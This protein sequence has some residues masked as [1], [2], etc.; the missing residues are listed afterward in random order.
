MVSLEEDSRRGDVAVGEDFRRWLS[1]EGLQ[2]V[3]VQDRMA[4]WVRR[5]GVRGLNALM[6]LQ[7]FFTQQPNLQYSPIKTF[8]G[9][10]STDTLNGSFHLKQ[11]K[12]L[13]KAKSDKD[14]FTRKQQR[15][16]H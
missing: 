14:L 15:K 11:P 6:L 3:D 1:I 10:T 8:Y 13:N 12:M 2:T 4:L 5:V 9:N 7:I 16:K